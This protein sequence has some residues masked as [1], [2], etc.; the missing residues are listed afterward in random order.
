MINRSINGTAGSTRVTD[1]SLKPS[2]KHQTSNKY[3]CIFDYLCWSYYAFHIIT[4]YPL[5]LIT[6]FCF[7]L[8]HR[9]LPFPFVLYLLRYTRKLE[10]QLQFHYSVSVNL[11]IVTILAQSFQP[12]PYFKSKSTRL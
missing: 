9:N 5:D 6:F 1:S 7:R 11:I 12:R 3:I 4:Q 8:E 10:I 2:N